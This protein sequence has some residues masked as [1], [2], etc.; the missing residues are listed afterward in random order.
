MSVILVPY[1]TLFR[2][3]R[4][5]NTHSFLNNWF[6]F[7]WNVVI[8]CLVNVTCWYVHY[9]FC[10]IHLSSSLV[11]FITSSN[12][13]LAITS[14]EAKGREC[15]FKFLSI[16]VTTFVSVPK[17][18]P[19]FETSLIIIASKFFLFSLIFPFANGSSV[20]AA[21]PTKN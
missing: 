21:K 7:F 11:D 8:K 6:K 16:Y 18:A 17:P 3:K 1:T 2:S 15:S 10:N 13:C 14:F 4:D 9:Y 20:S 5:D 19:S 12:I